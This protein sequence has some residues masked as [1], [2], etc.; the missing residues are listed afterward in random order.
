[1]EI[2]SVEAG[3]DE[4]VGVLK[5]VRTSSGFSRPGTKRALRGSGRGSCTGQAAPLRPF[6][7]DR[8]GRPT[9]RVNQLAQGEEA[10]SHP[11]RQSNDPVLTNRKLP[12]GFPSPCPGRKN[13]V[14][15]AGRMTLALT[16]SSP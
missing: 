13:C 6:A 15:T 11:F 14:S 9:A 7:N 2:P 5:V 3:K 12:S 8:E 4:G 1:M 10:Y 16:G